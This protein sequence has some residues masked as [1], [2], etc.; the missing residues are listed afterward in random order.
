MNTD[1][2]TF[3]SFYERE[4][5]TTARVLR[6]LPPDKAD[7][8][9]AEKSKSAKEVAVILV[10]EERMILRAFR[11]E[12]IM[13]SALP[14]PPATPGEIADLFD[15]QHQEVLQTLD[16]AGEDAMRRKVAFPVAPRKMGEYTLSEFIWFMMFDQIH[17]RG[18][19]SVYLRIAG[20]KVPSIYGPTAD[21]PWT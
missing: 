15:T 3:R 14:E 9:P 10:A 6:A 8:K 19:L 1:L 18:Q 11:G 17:H 21:E 4:H 20:A 16:Q 12:D 7:L 2:A 13:G 5:A